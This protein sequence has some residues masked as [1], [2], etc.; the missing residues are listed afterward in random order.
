LFMG[1][2]GGF[3]FLFGAEAGRAG[4]ERDAGESVEREA[5]RGLRAEAGRQ[6]GEVLQL[7]SKRQKIRGSSTKS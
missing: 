4:A 6:G 2:A 5:G 1:G 7:H 3:S